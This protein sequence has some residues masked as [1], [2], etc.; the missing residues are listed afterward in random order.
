MCNNRICIL[1]ENDKNIACCVETIRKI[2]TISC[3]VLHINCAILLYGC[4]MNEYVLLVKRAPLVYKNI[5]FL[6]KEQSFI[7]IIF[8]HH[9]QFFSLKFRQW[10][11]SSYIEPNQHSFDLKTTLTSKHFVSFNLTYLC[12]VLLISVQQSQIKFT[13]FRQAQSYRYISIRQLAI[14]HFTVEY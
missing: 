4:E 14:F 11:E 6:H 9:E 13:A 10:H 5:I 2:K 1:I 7:I 12:R 3:Y 8:I